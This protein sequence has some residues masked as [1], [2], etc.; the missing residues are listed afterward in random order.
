MK[1][2]IKTKE[3][4]EILKEGGKR[5][6]RIVDT[7]AKETK[8]GMSTWDLEE[9]A[10]ELIA[11]GGDIPAF[12]NYRPEG[13]PTPFPC[14]LCVSVN[15]EIVHGIPKKETILKNGDVVSIDC[16]LK[17]K[18]LFTDHATTVIVGEGT[19]VTRELLQVTK[20]SLMA[21]IE[22]AKAGN[23]TG[24]IGYA[25]SAVVRPHG[26]GVVRELAGHG[27]GKHIHEDPYIPNYGKNGAG[28][29]LQPGMV[30][31]IEPMIT[32]GKPDIVSLSDGY[33]I[34]TADGSK[35]AHFEHTVAITEDGPIILT[36]LE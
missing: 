14:A 17:H 35:S 1:I 10:R 22:M 23:K 26:F 7:L 13:A 19:K 3:E 16:G 24:D 12:L 33:T 11:E 28:V 15:S 5:L 20:E 32:I 6:A 2:I 25:V 36:E 27:V 18:G 4:I 30:I 21:G 31:A 29:L 9:R 34:K 8:A